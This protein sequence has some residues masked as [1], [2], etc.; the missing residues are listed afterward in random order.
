MKQLSFFILA[1]ICLNLCVLITSNRYTEF[2]A[3]Q[4]IHNNKIKNQGK[5]NSNNDIIDVLTEDD[6]SFDAEKILNWVSQVQ[7]KDLKSMEKDELNHNLEGIK[8]ASSKIQKYL[9]KTSAQIEASI[10]SID[11]LVHEINIID[12]RISEHKPDYKKDLEKIGNESDSLMKALEKEKDTVSRILNNLKKDNEDAEIISEKTEKAK[13]KVEFSDLFSEVKEKINNQLVSFMKLKYFDD[14]HKQ[15]MKEA[16]ETLL[17]NF[18]AYKKYDSEK[19]ASDLILRHWSNSLKLQ[20]IANREIITESF[21][22]KEE[23]HELKNKNENSNKDV[24]EVTSNKENDVNNN[25]QAKI[26]LQTKSEEL[27]TKKSIEKEFKKSSNTQIL[28]EIN[29]PSRKDEEID[30]E[31]E[32]EEEEEEDEEGEDEEEADSGKETE[33]ETEKKSEKEKEKKSQIKIQTEKENKK[34]QEQPKA[35]L[36][37]DVGKVQAKKKEKKVL[38]KENKKAVDDEDDEEDEQDD[39]ENEEEYEEEEEREELKNK[40]NKKDVESEFD[41]E[42]FDKNNKESREPNFI[43]KKRKSY[44]K[45]RKNRYH[46]KK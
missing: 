37:I 22:D 44:L 40:I 26:D 20:E 29:L 13:R 35:R 1:L 4:I 30:N 31:D 27:K 36:N 32:E 7:N 15:F 19:I 25:V 3:P 14:A 16:E 5:D 10:N 9:L 12:K 8:L 46:H 18:E 43:E 17:K 42:Y 21:N 38:E 6:H 33:K 23:K 34:L 2:E 11:L 39:D 41:K 28:G 45:K 24:K